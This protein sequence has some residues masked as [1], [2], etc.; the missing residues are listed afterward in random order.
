MTES[1]R[2]LARSL[3]PVHIGSGGYR[4]GRVDM[5]IVREPGTGIPKIP[6]TSL[7]GAIRA[8][9]ESAKEEDASLPDTAFV[10]G[11]A[12]GDGCDESRLS[13]YEGSS[14]DGRRRW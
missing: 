7:A 10:F 2:Y 3:D 4:L 12:A 11:E 1:R 9:A 14:R 8:Y 6:G 13:L 5:S